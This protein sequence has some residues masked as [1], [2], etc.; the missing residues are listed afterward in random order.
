MT[1]GE[2]SGHYADYDMPDFICDPFFQEWIIHPDGAQAAF[3]DDWVRR[4]PEKEKTV[5]EARLLLQSMFFEEDFPDESMAQR[6]LAMV[7]EKMG[8]MEQERTERERMEAEGTGY[9]FGPARAAGIRRIWWVAAVAA[10]VVIVAVI[11]YFLVG[12]ERTQRVH[13]TQYAE[14]QTLYLPDSSKVILNAHS[15]VRYS[16]EW[17]PGQAREVWLDGEAYFD[18][19]TEVA[20]TFFVHTKE[21]T[22]EVLGTI[23]DIRGRRG[24]AEIVLQSG[25][26]RI[27]FPGGGHD[28]VVMAPGDKIIYDPAK[29]SLAHAQIIPENYTAWKDK[30]LTDAT[31]QEII[32]YLEDN[33][34]RTII[35]DNDLLAHRKIGGVILLDNL[36][37]AL[38]A[39]ST[40][41]NVNIIQHQDTLI[42][43]PR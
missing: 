16:K 19:R 4:H 31:A 9:G 21:L 24:K 12:E 34:H 18:V 5:D 29:A 2:N 8:G 3:W 20:A 42:L 43:K 35:L 11:G 1:N 39:L 30:R 28:E 13:T 41:L 7:R 14:I 37:D 17:K 22:V 40:V 25:K 36:D 38:F 27:L 26:I 6:S 10:A 32:D 15:S 23:F 33:F